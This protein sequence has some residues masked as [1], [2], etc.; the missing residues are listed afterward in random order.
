MLSQSVWL[1]HGDGARYAAG[2]F[3]TKKDAM[4]WVAQ[5]RL[6]GLLTE[7]PLGVGAYD[8]AVAQGWFLPTKDHHGS[9]AHIAHF[10]PGRTEHVHLRDG[11]LVDG[12]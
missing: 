10:S 8:H 4:T 11:Q 2:V 12:D 5:H 6:S 1:F 9:P 3:A 7:Y